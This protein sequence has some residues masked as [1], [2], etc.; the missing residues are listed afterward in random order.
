[1]AARLQKFKATVTKRHTTMEDV[2]ALA[3]QLKL[4]PSEALTEFIV[5]T[6]CIGLLDWYRVRYK[7]AFTPTQRQKI[8]IASEAYEQRQVKETRETRWALLFMCL[9]MLFG[10]LNYFFSSRK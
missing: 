1:M 5:N 4:R 7:F 8:K 2:D 6:K 10:L 9:L 3:D